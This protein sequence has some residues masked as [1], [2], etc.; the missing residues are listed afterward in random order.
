MPE[1][2]NLEERLSSLYP[3]ISLPIVL[4]LLFDSTP[5]ICPSKI[6]GCV[7][8]TVLAYRKN[9]NSNIDAWMAEI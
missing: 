7:I 2:Q 3:Y 6:K 1:H 9:G 5:E 8:H 4:L